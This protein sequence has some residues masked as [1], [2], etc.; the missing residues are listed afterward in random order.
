MQH[1]RDKNFEFSSFYQVSHKTKTI[2]ASFYRAPPEPTIVVCEFRTREHLLIAYTYT[3]TH[4]RPKSFNA[5]VLPRL[6]KFPSIRRI[7][8]MRLNRNS[9]LRDRS[10]RSNTTGRK[11]NPEGREQVRGNDERGWKKRV[12]FEGFADL[13][14]ARLLVCVRESIRDCYMT[15]HRKKPV[16]VAE[17]SSK[18]RNGEC[19]I[20]RKHQWKKLEV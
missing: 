1:L 16:C 3:Y 2:Q 11:K 13:P 18:W 20:A 5:V 4:A 8:P 6:I 15:L 9:R 12:D 17:I 10:R 19:E 7:S 14:C